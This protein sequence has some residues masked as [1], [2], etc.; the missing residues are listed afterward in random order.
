MRL[1]TKK[2]V[3]ELFTALFCVILTTSFM[4]AQ[5]VYGVHAGFG[6][7]YAV[8]KIDKKRMIIFQRYGDTM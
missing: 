2:M 8:R 1:A 4:Q 5:N 6:G 3:E 7:A